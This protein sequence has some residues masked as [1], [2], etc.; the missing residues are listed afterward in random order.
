MDQKNVENIDLR[1]HW[2]RRLELEKYWGAIASLNLKG[3]DNV[4]L[5][6]DDDGGNW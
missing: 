1:C 2:W 6:V 4:G 3:D 5:D